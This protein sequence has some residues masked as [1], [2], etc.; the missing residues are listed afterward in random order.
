MSMNYCAQIFVATTNSASVT[1]EF[2]NSFV[3]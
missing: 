3:T 1:F 2:E